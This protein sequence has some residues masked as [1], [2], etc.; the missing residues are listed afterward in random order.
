LKVTW[1]DEDEV[2]RLARHLGV[3]VHRKDMVR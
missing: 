3:K 1:L 2:R